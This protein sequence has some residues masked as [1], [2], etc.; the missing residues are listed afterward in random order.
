MI[1]KRLHCCIFVLPDQGFVED[2]WKVETP[3]GA[4]DRPQGQDS[5][6][7]DNFFLLQSTIYHHVHSTRFFNGMLSNSSCVL[8]P[9]LDAGR[10]NEMICLDARQN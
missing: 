5:L 2:V 1:L 6:H 7:G 4:R 10:D 3:V 9:P 8:L